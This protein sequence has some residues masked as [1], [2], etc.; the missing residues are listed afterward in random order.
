M[1]PDNSTLRVL[2]FNHAP[3]VTKP[4]PTETVSLE[5]KN[6][7]LTG[8]VKVSIWRV[9]EDH[10]DFWPQWEK[11]RAE[12][13]ITDDDYYQSR[14]Q[15]DPAHA[16]LKGEHVEFWKSKE[17]EY[18]EI[19]QL[20]DPTVEYR[21]VKNGRFRLELDLPCFSVAFLEVSQVD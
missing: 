19:A 17:P 5:M 12:H 8:K 2:A 18:A 16:L 14:D 10:G 21:Q 1:A 13:G 6:L 11:D 20:T 3:K 4:N 7:S 9:D 15:V